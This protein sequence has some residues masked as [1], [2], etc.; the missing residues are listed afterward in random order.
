[1][2]RRPPRST[3]TDTLFPYTTLFRSDELADRAVR[4]LFHLARQNAHRGLSPGGEKAEKQPDDDENP[5]LMQCAECN[6]D[7]PPEGQKSDADSPQEQEQAAR[8]DRRPFQ[9]GER[10]STRLSSSK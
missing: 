9:D 2:I 3:R 5:R 7:C 8:R 10:K 1:M 6:A 4:S